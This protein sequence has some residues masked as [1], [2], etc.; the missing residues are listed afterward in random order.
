MIQLTER[1][2]NDAGG[3]RAM[4]AARAIAAAG[5]VSDAAWEE[6]WL[7]GRVREG[8]TEYRAG[9]KILS[10]TNVENLCTCRVS[11]QHG[12]ICAHSLAVGLAWLKPPVEKVELAEP[13]P[14]PPPIGANARIVAD[15]GVVFNCEESAEDIVTVIIPPK[16]GKTFER[17]GA[18]V[19][20]EVQLGARSVPASELPSSST[21]RCSI[22]DGRMIECL[23][24]FTGGKLPGMVSLG[25]GDVLQ[26]LKAAAGHSTVTLVGEKGRKSARKRPARG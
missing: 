26:L 25:R 18:T 6:P 8:E 17:G 5:R 19:A 16:V 9:L 23:L 22:S 13:E 1:L 4:K 21:H 15:R 11:R 14:T 7:R 20:V 10:K 3:W 2:L 12:A 24:R